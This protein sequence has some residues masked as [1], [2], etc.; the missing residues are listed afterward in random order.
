[1]AT[2]RVSLYLSPESEPKLASRREK[3]TATYCNSLPCLVQ[4][5][6]NCSAAKEED[7]HPNAVGRWERVF[8]D[9]MVCQAIAN[10]ACYSGDALDCQYRCNN[11]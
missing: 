1:M 4:G 5:L 6:L 8:K 10:R 7:P 3:S 11:P 2:A 9:L